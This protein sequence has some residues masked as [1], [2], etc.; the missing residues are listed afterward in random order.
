MLILEL[1][2]GH[3]KGKT[4]ISYPQPIEKKV[5]DLDY[6][7]I[8]AFI[9]KK[10]GHDVIENILTYLAYDFIEKRPGGAKVAAPSYM[11]DV[12]R[13]CDVVEEILRIYSYN[14]IE[15]PQHMKMS[16]GTTPDRI[17]SNQELHF[18]LP[19]CGRFRRDHEQLPDKGRIL[20]RTPDI[21]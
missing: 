7:R 16:V 11:I 10:L 12:Y 14:N 9:G 15:L 4:R 8:E 2:G 5:I 3:I 6:D 13:E 19:R 21:P 17:R 20:F 18:Q 1:A